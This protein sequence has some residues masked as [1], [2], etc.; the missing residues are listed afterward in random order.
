MD[1]RAMCAAHGRMRDGTAGPHG[2]MM[3][4]HMKEMSPEM[5]ERHMEMMRRHCK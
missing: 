5:R 3:E 4:R 1:M 2:A